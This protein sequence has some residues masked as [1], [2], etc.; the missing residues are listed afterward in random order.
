MLQAYK[1]IESSGLDIAMRLKQKWLCT[2]INVLFAFDPQVNESTN[3]ASPNFASDIT[4]T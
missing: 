3:G 1:V 2:K 4:Q